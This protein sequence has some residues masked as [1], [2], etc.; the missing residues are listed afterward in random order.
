[1]EI[2]RDDSL[3]I[4]RTMG[5]ERGGQVRERRNVETCAL[6]PELAYLDII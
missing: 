1:M 4:N 3:R 6:L 2:A 5:G